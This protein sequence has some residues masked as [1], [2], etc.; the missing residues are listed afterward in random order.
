[1]EKETFV[2]N[3]DVDLMDGVCSVCCEIP[4]LKKIRRVEARRLNVVDPQNVGAMVANQIF[5]CS[6]NMWAWE[7]R[8]FI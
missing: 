3:K 4:D 6:E 2:S 5:K 8:G 7:P 1:M